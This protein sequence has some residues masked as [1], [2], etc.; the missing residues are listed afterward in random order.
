MSDLELFNLGEP[1][2]QH[3]KRGNSFRFGK[4]G[5][6]FRYG[7]RQDDRNQVA[8]VLHDFSLDHEISVYDLLKVISQLKQMEDQEYARV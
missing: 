8:E 4:R 6:A 7:K 2:S 3:E 5:S 1:K